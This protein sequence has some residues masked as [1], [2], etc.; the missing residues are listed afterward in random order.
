MKY[1]FALGLLAAVLPVS[2]GSAQEVDRQMIVA[3]RTA[4]AKLDWMNGTWR[5]EAVT[6]GRNGE[7]RVTQTE[8]IGSLLDGTVKVIEGKAYNADGSV[9]FNALGIVSFDPAAN[10]Y[11]LHSYAQ[12]RAGTFSFTPTPSGYVWEI[13]V[14]PMTIRY[15]MTL[16]DGTWNEVGDRIAAGKPSVRFFEMNLKRVGDTDWPAAGGPQPR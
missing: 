12:G 11:A 13:P 14:G 3:E 10:A 16:K 9:G 2:A 15:T 1:L 7:H 8:R 6:Q 4:M 5:G